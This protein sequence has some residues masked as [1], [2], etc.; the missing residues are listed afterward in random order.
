MTVLAQDQTNLMMILDASGSMWA[1]IED[2]EKIVIA[3]KA[4]VEF[5]N[6]LPTDI[7]LGVIAYGH[8]RKGDCNDVELIS[9]LGKPDKNSIIKKIMALNPKGMTPI[10][11][12]LEM[13]IS[14]LKGISGNNLI[15]LISDGEETCGSDPCAL[16]AKY[17]KESR[18][19]TVHVIGFDVKGIA[20]KQLACIAKAGCGG[21]YTA[22]NMN[23]LLLAVSHVSRTVKLKKG[24]L[25]LEKNTFVP[26]EA[27]RLAFSTEEEYTEK[28]WIGIIPS[29]IPHGDENTNDQHDLDYRYLQGQRSGVYDFDAPSKPGKYDFR[30]HD[31]NDNGKE[32]AHIS[33]TV[34]P[35]QG[36]LSLS[37][38]E[39]F[40]SEAITVSFNSDMKLSKKAWI[41]ILPANITHGDESQNDQYDLDYRYLNGQSTGSVKFRAPG[42]P[43]K[44]DFRLH[45]TDDNGKELAS[46]SFEVIPVSGSLSLLKSTAITNGKIEVQLQEAAQLSSKAWIGLIPSDIPH[47]DESRNDQHDLD[48]KYVRSGDNQVYSFLAPSKTGSFD[49]RLHDT[50]DNGSEIASVTFQVIM[51]KADIKTNKPAF[52]KGESIKI[53]FSFNGIPAQNAW[54]G[55]F[56]AGSTPPKKNYLTY[57]YTAGKQT[58]RVE[59]PAPQK[60]G[61]YDLRVF[62][63]DRNDANLLNQITISVK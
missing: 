27:I 34:I 19:F 14:K 12:S 47:G 32:I 21:Y 58:G 10:T 3:K 53:D 39:Y 44:Y 15:V 1:K 37:Q 22:R 20:D 16:V 26:G 48:Y 49:F 42:Q 7:Q 40:P 63:A 31:T 23:D 35:T 38:K 36:S 5:V 24:A 25:D 62:D 51:A 52:G 54:I 46:V 30:L 43:G 60:S 9:A 50:D 11:L 33:F 17:M 13:A 2:K 6:G 59:M 18:N 29:E 45:D 56:P 57:K 4:F 28:G 55:I 41:G 8:N 61:S